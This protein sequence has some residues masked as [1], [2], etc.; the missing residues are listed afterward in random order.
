METRKNASRAAYDT[1]FEN[2]SILREVSNYVSLEMDIPLELAK[3]IV[4]SIFAI[5]SGAVT[6]S[7][8]AADAHYW[9]VVIELLWFGLTEHLQV[10]EVKM[11]ATLKCAADALHERIGNGLDLLAKLR[12]VGLSRKDIAEVVGRRVRENLEREVPPSS[13]S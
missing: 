7:G 9:A 3:T 2:L 5:N 13:D 12:S 4:Y 8:D 1:M 11:R 10:S 6:A